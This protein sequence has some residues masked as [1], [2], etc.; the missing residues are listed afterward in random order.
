[1]GKQA[2]LKQARRQQLLQSPRSTGR[3]RSGTYFWVGFAA[4]IAVAAAVAIFVGGDDGGSDAAGPEAA[5]VSVEG[6]ALPVFDANASADPSVGMSAPGAA[7]TSL[8][9]GRIT[10]PAGGGTPR[11]L[12]F[13]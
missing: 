8:S 1:M 3:Q 12:I 11:V 9:G 7:G 6:S 10:I 13:L 4:L 5:A 2:R